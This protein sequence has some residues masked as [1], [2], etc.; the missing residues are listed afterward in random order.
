MQ[1]D[2]PNMIPL[3]QMYRP[4]AELKAKAAFYAR[5]SAMQAFKEVDDGDDALMNRILWFA[6]KGEE[7]YPAATVK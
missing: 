6:A 5:L 2:L 4:L 1:T 3:D 7:Q